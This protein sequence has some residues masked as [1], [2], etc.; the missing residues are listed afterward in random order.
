MRIVVAGPGAIG[1]LFAAKIACRSAHEVWLLDRHEKRAGEIAER[2]LTLV[3]GNKNTCTEVRSTAKV[4]QIGAAD[5]ILLC[6]KS[7]DVSKAIVQLLPLA[8]ENNLLIA[9]QNGIAHHKVLDHEYPGSWAVGVTAQ[10]ASLISPGLVKHGGSGKTYLGY[11]NEKKNAVRLADLSCLLN[12]HGLEAEL[13]DDILVQV[14]NKLIVNIGINALTVLLDSPNGHILDSVSG[15]ARMVLAVREAARVAAS[16]GIVL[17]DDPVAMTEKVCR[18][19]AKNISSMLQDVRAHRRTEI[20][21]INGALIYEAAL[22]G[23]SVPEN[24]RLVKEIKEVEAGYL[25]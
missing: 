10:G 3:E 14:W 22:H 17:S 2:G 4:D 5:I 13:S 11:I 18:A 16:K 7:H 1:C 21:A 24:E 9:M 6:V 12:E 20:D 25:N 15:R 23:V 19:T 8:N